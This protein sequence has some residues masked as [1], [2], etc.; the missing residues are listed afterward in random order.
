MKTHIVLIK[1]N[2]S[3]D[4]RPFLEYHEG[5]VFHS[6][7][8][9]LEVQK[10]INKKAGSEIAEVWPMDAFMEAWNDTDDDSTH[11]DVKECFMGYVYTN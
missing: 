6:C 1:P 7:S 9:S 8:S 3:V 11:I 2:S 10:A 5:T 4:A